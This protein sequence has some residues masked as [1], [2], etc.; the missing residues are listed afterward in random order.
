MA[1][2]STSGAFLQ[3]S[4]YMT[5]PMFTSKYLLM[6]PYG[7]LKSEYD[8][9]RVLRPTT[10]LSVMVTIPTVSIL[11]LCPYTNSNWL[12]APSRTSL[13]CNSQQQF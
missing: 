6:G 9:W 3:A 10:I 8:L 13:T 11:I 12:L 7:N 1:S 2:Q 5:M 4:P